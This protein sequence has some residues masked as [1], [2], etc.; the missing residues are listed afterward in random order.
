MP[1]T[2]RKSLSLK[3]TDVGLKRVRQDR[4]LHIPLR[5]PKAKRADGL[6][7]VAAEAEAPILYPPYDLERR[8]LA[9][10]PRAQLV[11]GPVAAGDDEEAAGP[12]QRRD[13]RSVALARAPAVRAARVREADGVEGALVRDDVPAVALR[14][15]EHVG[16]G[17][18]QHVPGPEGGVAAFLVGDAAGEL[19]ALGA[20]VHALEAACPAVGAQGGE[21]GAVAAAEVEEGGLGGQGEGG[22]VGEELLLGV[23]VREPGR[24][25]VLGV[26]GV[27]LELGGVQGIPAFKCPVC[28]LVLLFS[29]ISF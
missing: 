20:V 3:R 21:E 19:D 4:G 18:R 26:G 29:Y 2:D 10:E 7:L 17:A 22:Q 24:A 15:V 8:P 13:A 23:R 1:S 16:V 6:A 28:Q 5:L 14:A 25:G 11:L 9:G 27:V 12:H